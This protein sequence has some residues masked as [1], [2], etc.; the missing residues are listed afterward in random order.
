MNEIIRI[1]KIERRKPSD[2]GALNFV[3]HPLETIFVIFTKDGKVWEYN[4]NTQQTKHINT[5]EVGQCCYKERIA[6]LREALNFIDNT[7]PGMY[8]YNE[9]EL[10]M[11]LAARAAIEKDNQYGK[12]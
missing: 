1:E 10:R 11:V 7:A 6:A 4:Y 5:L 12:A 9:V 3:V 2:T 8:E